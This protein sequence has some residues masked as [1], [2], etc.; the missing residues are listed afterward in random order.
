MILEEEAS[1]EFLDKQ[2]FLGA[3]ESLCTEEF[4]Y[5]EEFLDKAGSIA[6]ALRELDC[7]VSNRWVREEIERLLREVKSLENPTLHCS[8]AIGLREQEDE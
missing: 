6:A 1:E 4:L 8:L 7:P 3:E 2:E 5:R